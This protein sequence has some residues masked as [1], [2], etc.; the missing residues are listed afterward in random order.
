MKK[1]I[2][3]PIIGIAVCSLLGW[4]RFNVI[5]SDFLHASRYSAG[6]NAGYTG[7]PGESNCTNCHSGTVLSGSDENIFTISLGGVGALEYTPGE[8]Y[9]LS[10]TTASNVAKKGFEITALDENN[11]PAGEFVASSNTQLKSPTSGLFAGRKYVT[12]TSGTNSPTGWQFTWTAPNAIVGEITFYL[13]TN[14]SNSSNSTAGDEIYLSQYS[15]NTSAGLVEKTSMNE[16]FE[17]GYSPESN[18]LVIRFDDIQPGEMFLNLVDLNGK[19]VFTQKLG[20]S[21][22]GSNIQKIRLPEGI[23]NGIHFVNFFV[24]NKALAGKVLVSK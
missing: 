19:S 2:I 3:L 7:A 15:L 6:A 10:L 12:H 9:D 14:K 4:Q 16:H 8:V 20:K 5:S 22:E 13:A 17:V 21:I 1:I 23:K 18:Q 24:D 11:N